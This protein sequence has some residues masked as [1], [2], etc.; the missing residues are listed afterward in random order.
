MN[1]GA[2]ENEVAKHEW[3]N[4]TMEPAHW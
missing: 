4:S 1:E 2:T 3:G